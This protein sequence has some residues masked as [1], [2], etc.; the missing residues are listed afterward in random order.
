MLSEPMTL[1]KLM[2]LYMLKQ[3]NFPL[4]NA[5]LSNFFLDREYTTYF[6][7]QQALGELLEAGLIK[8]ETLHNSTRYEITREGEETLEF[9]GKKISP[10]IVE[11][12]DEYLK[13]NRFRMRN[14]VGLVS[15]FY[16]STNQ[17]YIVH[18]EV[19]EGKNVLVNIDVSVPDKEQAE[20]MCSH[21]KDRSQEIY[22]Y[23][24]KSLM[25]DES[26]GKGK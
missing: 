13:E 8:M 18:C 17:D 25:S 4:T 12:M 3:V 26:S 10:A 5:Q 16:K 19:R 2:N 21:W 24:M 9:F 15:D 14:E 11:D 7:L 20:I 6:T 22:A 1:Y 23:I